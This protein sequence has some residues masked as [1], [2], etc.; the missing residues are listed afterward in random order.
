MPDS[1]VSTSTT[2][3]DKT[4]V[5]LVQRRLEEELRAPLVHLA[6]ALPAQFIPGTNLMRYIRYED[7]GSVPG[8]VTAPSGA[9]WLTEGTPPDAVSLNIGYDE[10][11]AHQAGVVIRISDV[12]LTQSPHDLI[13]VGTD[14]GLFD[15]KRLIDRYIAGV[16]ANGTNKVNPNG[17][18]TTATIATT[19]LLTGALVKQAVAKLR[20]ASVPTF[21]DGY[22]HCIIHPTV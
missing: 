6:D 18:S 2:D 19:D 4:V 1:Q 17:H 8:D 9:P 20:A 14:R 3:F 7:I 22:Y 21:G 15:A 11:G 10:F 16:I 12:A 5:A 13:A